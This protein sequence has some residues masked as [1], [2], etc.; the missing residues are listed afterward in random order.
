MPR[1]TEFLKE[2]SNLRRDLQLSCYLQGFTDLVVKWKILRVL[3]IPH[4]RRVFQKS[5]NVWGIGIT[6]GLFSKLNMFLG[7][8]S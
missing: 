6:L 4:L 2:I 1:T 8:H 3:C 5:S 7:V